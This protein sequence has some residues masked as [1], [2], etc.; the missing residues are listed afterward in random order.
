MY[1]IYF[2]GELFDHKHITGN[3]LL[4]QCIEKLSNDRYKCILPQ[5]TEGSFNTA[6]AL[7]NRDIMYVLQA[8]MVLFN[9]DGLDLD[10]GTVVEFMLAKMLDIPAVLLRTESRNG[11]YL[12]GDDWNLMV[13]GYPRCIVVKHPALT[14]YNVLGLE[15]MHNTI[16]LSVVDALTNVLQEQSLFTSY[17]EIFAAYQHVIKMC[18]AKLEQQVQPQM[19]HELISAK[20]KKSIYLVNLP[21]KPKTPARL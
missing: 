14:R 5:N 6:L 1:N 2:A 17:D 19:V 15:K 7:R 12:F 13:D 8:D 10:S 4:A 18:G 16:A 20:I 21:V 9:F 11:G 3:L